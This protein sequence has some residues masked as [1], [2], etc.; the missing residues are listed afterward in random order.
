MLHVLYHACP[1]LRSPILAGG[2][3]SRTKEAETDQRN[4]RQHQRHGLSDVRLPSLQRGDELAKETRADADDDREHHHL[5]AGRHDI[6]ED[7]LGEERGL[8]PE[9]SEERRVGKEC[10]STC[11]SRWSTYHSTKNKLALEYIDI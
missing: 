8:V 7:A 11:R 1:P 9:R 6:A 10:V 4:R 3:D 5:D 2:S